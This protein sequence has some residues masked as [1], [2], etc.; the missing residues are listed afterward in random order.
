M[1]VELYTI[2]NTTHLP[3][4]HFAQ[5]Y[6]LCSLWLEAI[7]CCDLRRLLSAWP[8]HISIKTEIISNK[9]GLPYMSSISAF[10]EQAS[11]SCSFC[12]KHF[13]REG[14]WNLSISSVSSFSYFHKYPLKEFKYHSSQTSPPHWHTWKHEN[15]TPKFN[16]TNCTASILSKPLS[17]FFFFFSSITRRSQR[18][19]RQSSILMIGLFYQFISFSVLIS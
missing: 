15:A 7:F 6:D 5:N 18:M 8:L 19:K 9:Y 10:S 2:I 3:T 1:V 14:S 17:L 12:P 16:C 4:H 11:V 13:H